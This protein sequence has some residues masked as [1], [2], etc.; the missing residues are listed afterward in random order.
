MGSKKA[1]VR[2]G[3]YFGVWGSWAGFFVYRVCTFVVGTKGLR[4]GFA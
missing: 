2:F 1:W 4:M 3:F